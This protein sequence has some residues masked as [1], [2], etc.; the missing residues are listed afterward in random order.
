MKGGKGIRLESL[1]QK[2]IMLTLW[3]Q[4][5]RTPTGENKS[6]RFEPMLGQVNCMALLLTVIYKAFLHCQK[7]NISS[8]ALGNTLLIQTPGKH[9][10]RSKRTDKMATWILEIIQLNKTI[11]ANC[12][13][14]TCL[15]LSPLSSSFLDL[16]KQGKLDQI[17]QELPSR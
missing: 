1:R 4:D 17:R 6:A 12:N 10:H 11:Q 14:T 8:D 15:S 9:T 5:S 2:M 7:K 13:I 16:V 3:I